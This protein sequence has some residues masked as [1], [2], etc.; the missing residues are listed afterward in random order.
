MFVAV[1]QAIFQRVFGSP[2]APPSWNV[3]LLIYAHMIRFAMAN[4]DWIRIRRLTELYDLI[5]RIRLWFTGCQ[6]E[7]IVRKFDE[8]IV[9]GAW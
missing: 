7:R 2:N 1:P 5:E 6:V 3:L 9:N 8:R 4:G